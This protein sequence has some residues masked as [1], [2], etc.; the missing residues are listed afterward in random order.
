MA[1]LITGSIV[2]LFGVLLFMIASPLGGVILIVFGV[3]VA[4]IGIS[5]YTAKTV[6][7]A[8]I[9]TQAF[10]DG[11]V[12]ERK[13]P[14][15]AEFVKAEAILCRYC[16]SE[17]PML[18]VNSE[19]TK[20]LQHMEFRLLVAAGSGDSKLVSK[21]IE[22]GAAVNCQDERGESPLIKAALGNHIE[23][24]R[25]LMKFRADPRIPNEQ[26]YTAEDYARAR[27]YRDL[28]NVLRGR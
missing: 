15:C 3:T 23:V 16:R 18:I 19:I 7:R 1:L 5:R 25:V 9:H 20:E 22:E 24:V 28:L 2:L 27:D 8:I 14:F 4:L 13:C 26:G 12:V 21:L 17:L 11:H 6:S 10:S